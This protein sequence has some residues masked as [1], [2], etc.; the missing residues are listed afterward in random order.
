MAATR[1]ASSLQRRMAGDG[2]PS[3]RRW[4]TAAGS[5][6][7]STGE[8]R[9]PAAARRRRTSR[10]FQRWYTDPEVARLTRYQDGPMRP[11]EIERFFAAR[12]LGP[13][14]LSM[15]I[16]LR[17]YEPAHR[18]VRAV[19]ARPRQRLGAVPHHDRREGRLGPR[20]R[21]RGDAA[22]ARPRVRDA[23]PAPD[24]RCRCSRST[25]G[26]SAPTS[27]VGFVDRG[28]RPRGD[29]ARRPVV[30][31]D[32]DERPRLRLGRDAARRRQRR[33]RPARRASQLPARPSGG[34]RA[35]GFL[36]RGADELD[37]PGGRRGPGRLPRR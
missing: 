22:D 5:P 12:A 3:L 2:I 33:P 34:S 24:R 35:A 16:H 23:G 14:S 13:D 1:S 32:R 10:A 26:R 37:G 30:G 31:R 25:S 36:S 7:C 20:L 4:P 19:A 21:H 27:R 29:L 18:D 11:D 28:P 17:G 8:S 6:I 15:A 9:R